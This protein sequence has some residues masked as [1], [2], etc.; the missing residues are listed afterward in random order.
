MASSTNGVASYTYDVFGAVRSRSGSSDNPWLFT[1]EQR[2]SESGLYYL[3]ARYYDPGIGRFLGRDPLRGELLNPQTQNRYPYV[4]NN[5]VLLID[6]RG[7]CG[8]LDPGDGR[9]PG[10]L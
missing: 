3:R 9:V 2:D 5:P 6:P 1:G 8:V 10:V 7:L 4:R